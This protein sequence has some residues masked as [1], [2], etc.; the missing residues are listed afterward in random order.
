[1]RGNCVRSL[2]GART[3]PSLRPG[4]GLFTV[5]GAWCCFSGTGASFVYAQGLCYRPCSDGEILMLK[6]DVS[7]EQTWHGPR[8]VRAGEQNKQH[9]TTCPPSATSADIDSCYVVCARRK[10]KL[11]H[12][13]WRNRLGTTA[14]MWIVILH[15][16]SPIKVGRE[17]R[18]TP[19]DR[20]SST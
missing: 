10:D 6:Q 1:M 13:P 7:T 18:E 16:V 3:Q 12:H 17:A 2:S 15:W 4:S 20:R 11:T 8:C 5:C 14:S 9:N 19:T